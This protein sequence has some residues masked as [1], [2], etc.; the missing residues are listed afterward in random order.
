MFL[1][2]DPNQ[3]EN[4]PGLPTCYSRAWLKLK[5]L[6]DQVAMRE[7]ELIHGGLVMPAIMSAKTHCHILIDVSLATTYIQGW[8]YVL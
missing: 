7:A 6:H 2:G 1:T 3:T 4:L 8:I 5:E